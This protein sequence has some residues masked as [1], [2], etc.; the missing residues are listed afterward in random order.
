[1]A[2]N[3]VIIKY[4][5]HLCNILKVQP[6][7]ISFNSD[8]VRQDMSG[9][10]RCFFKRCTC[11]QLPV[12]IKNE[13]NTIGFLNIIFEAL[14]ECNLPLVGKSIEDRAEIRQW[15]EYVLLYVANAEN[16]NAVSNVLRVSIQKQRA[17]LIISLCILNCQRQGVAIL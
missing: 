9:V 1:M 8:M 15:V 12:R 7:K 17:K 3:S 10:N 4:I 2:T 14:Q 11:F 16:G 5:S 6:G 13:K